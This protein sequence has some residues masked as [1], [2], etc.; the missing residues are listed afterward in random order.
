MSRVHKY[1]AWYKPSKQMLRVIGINWDF[2]NGEITDIDYVEK[3]RHGDL[4]WNANIDN[5]E[6]MEFTGSLDKNNVEIYEGDIIKHE[7]KNPITREQ[8]SI[9]IWEVKFGD[10]DN[11]YGYEDNISGYGWHLYPISKTY[12]G[13][14]KQVTDGD[15]E[16]MADGMDYAEIIGNIFMNPE[17]LEE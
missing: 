7:S 5:V 17:Y 8:M 2:E 6:L 16:D 14:K 12:R 10:Y 15:I 11:G 9:T 13:N 4:I 3:D 1:R